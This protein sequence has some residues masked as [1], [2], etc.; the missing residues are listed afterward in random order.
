LAAFSIPFSLIIGSDALISGLFKDD[1]G[2]FYYIAC[3]R[4]NQSAFLCK[5]SFFWQTSHFLAFLILCFVC[6]FLGAQNWFLGLF[7]AIM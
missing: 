6:I 5:E 2:F 4:L 1:W 3:V 7:E